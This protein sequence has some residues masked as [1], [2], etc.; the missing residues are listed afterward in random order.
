MQGHGGYPSTESAYPR[1]VRINGSTSEYLAETEF[2]TSMKKTDEAFADLI[3]FFRSYKEPT[4][5]V[6]YGD[7]QPSLSQNFILNLWMK[8]THQQN[9]LLLLLSG[10]IFISKS[11]KLQPSAQITLYHT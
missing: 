8:M 4:I 11:V 10:Q 2:L 5:I 9:I 7:H 6:M 1:E 3:S